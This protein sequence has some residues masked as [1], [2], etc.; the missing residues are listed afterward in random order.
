MTFSRRT[1]LQTAA[2]STALVA[3]S[4]AVPG[5]LLEA[6]EQGGK[7]SGQQ[8]LVVVQLSGGNDGLNTI[9]PFTDPAYK[10]NRF[11]LALPPEGVLKIDKELGFNPVMRGMANL[12]EDG[13]LA[14]VQGVGYPNPNR[15]HFESMDLW[16]TAHRHA[17]A[18]PLGWLGRY[19]DDSVKTDGRDVPALHLGEEKQP[20]ALTALNVSTPSVRSLERFKIDVGGNES[21]RKAIASSTSAER[22]A[23]N[24]L[25]DF[26]KQSTTAALTSSRRVEESLGAYKTP[27]N[28]PNSGLGRKLKTVAQLVDAGLSTRI[29]YLALDGFDTHSNQAPA[30]TAL[31]TE[32][33]EAV[34]AFWEDL[35]HHGHADRT[36]LLTF[37][38]FGR[39]VK[40]NAS[41]GT[42]HGAA[43]PMLCV[44]GKV[45]PGLIGAHPSLTDLDDGDLKHHTD[46]RQ[47]YATVLEDW[48]GWPSEPI[49]GG[50]YKKVGLFST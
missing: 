42:D 35:S 16:H 41:Q 24:E 1:F 3:L 45:K 39:R 7:S 4:R 15:S 22:P 6:A 44:G 33:S 38:E 19:L 28:Y 50:S 47:V 36:L 46:Y 31:L 11:A 14:I 27:V 25:L 29:Y 43:A 9:V 37:S 21:L 34:A 48:L 8:I 5:F 30:H 20:L 12:L 2:G 40:E 18:R 23:G 26:V 13:K 49:L 10:K 17:T 32:L